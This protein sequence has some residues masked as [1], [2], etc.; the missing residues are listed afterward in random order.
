MLAASPTIV[1]SAPAPPLASTRRGAI[2]A[3]VSAKGGTGKTIIAATTV[4]LLTRAG[5]RV[6]AIDTDFSTRGLSLYLLGQ[7]TSTDLELQPEN[8]L[9]DCLLEDR[10]VESVVPRLFR[11]DGMDYHI[12]FASR[13]IR[14]GGKSD[15]RLLGSE[16]SENALA[17]RYTRYL[18]DLCRELRKKYDYV[19]IDSR[20]GYDFTSA[21]AALAADSYVVVLE[22]D[23]LSLDQVAALLAGISDSAASLSVVNALKGF[24]VNKAL[25]STR[26]SLFPEELQRRYQAKTLGIIPAD[27]KAIAAYQHKGIP[28]VRSPD[29]DFAYYSSKVVAQMVN[30]HDNWEAEDAKRFAKMQETIRL[31]WS[32][33]RNLEMIRE[34][35][36]LAVFAL[37]AFAVGSYLNY[38]SGAGALVPFVIATAAAVLL[39]FYGSL[40]QSLHYLRVRTEVPRWTRI[41]LGVGGIVVA[42]SVSALV[43]FDLP[44][45]FSRD[46]LLA[47][48]VAQ[49]ARIDQTR[50]REDSLRL[51]LGAA[52]ERVA[53][54]SQD[55]LALQRDRQRVDSVVVRLQTRLDSATANASN[56]QRRIRDSLFLVTSQVAVL[57][58]SL[59]RRATSSE[60]FR[61]LSGEW[62]EDSRRG[63][64]RLLV[65]GQG[66]RAFAALATGPLRSGIDTSVVLFD[67]GFVG[68]EEI[69]LESRP[70]VRAR[71][72]SRLT[73]RAP[74]G[75]LM[76]ARLSGPEGTISIE[77]R[78]LS[79]Q[80]AR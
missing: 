68:F 29:C 43:V 45:V 27:L 73:L 5:K 78:R 33:R 61:E 11:R 64:T 36:P 3:F 42:V 6:V 14:G 76:L 77:F 1:P 21:G 49:Q 7:A 2:Y 18:A 41:G 37:L 55:S 32:T 66:S 22:A 53:L 38:R 71:G 63:R 19:I 30:P 65:G 23:K 79:A 67:G 50:S 44:S 24:I 25:F 16:G 34:T 80:A 74:K 39:A 4:H 35:T 75:G 20:G 57:N 40:V 52:E 58:D 54:L 26:D 10:P 59:R 28:V 69:V 60:P 46:E 31:D 47:R 12:V 62:V 70:F 8:C 13:L 56:A 17:P 51:A 15:A 48:I 72:T 9:A